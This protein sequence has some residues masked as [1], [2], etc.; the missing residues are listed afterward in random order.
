[1]S[2]KCQKRPLCEKRVRVVQPRRMTSR[3]FR[4]KIERRRFL[5]EQH[6]IVPWRHDDGGAEA[7]RL[8]A[9][10]QRD[11]QHQ[12]RGNLVPA[13]EMMLDREARVKAKRFGFDIEIEEF[14]KALAGFRVDRVLGDYRGRPWDDRA[15]AWLILGRKK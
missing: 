15:E 8:C 13:A 5:G 9:H 7:K 11:K 4:K 3:A 1:M 14:K 2:S 10:G 12:G 6:R